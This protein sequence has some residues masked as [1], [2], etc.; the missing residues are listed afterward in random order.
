MLDAEGFT[1]FQKKGVLDTETGRSFREH[2]LNKGNAAWL[3]NFPA[4]S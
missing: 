4:D 3:K 2:I 1:R